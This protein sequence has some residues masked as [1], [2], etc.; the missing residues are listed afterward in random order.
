VLVA[1]GASMI[2]LGRRAR[3]ALLI[4]YACECASPSLPLLLILPSTADSHATG[5]CR[6]RHAN[7]VPPCRAASPL[8]RVLYRP[9]GAGAA[10]AANPPYSSPAGAAVAW[11]PGDMR[12]RGR[13]LCM[14][15]GHGFF[16]WP[17]R[18]SR[19]RC[20]HT[21]PSRSR[22]ASAAPVGLHGAAVSHADAE[23]AR[24][25]SQLQRPCSRTAA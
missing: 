1:C 10:S 16:A 14:P 13:G 12:D 18:A 15:P 21:P 19:K 3:V 17:R 5:R 23:G 9:M 22:V 2:A 6:F 24:A 8:M 4:R 25:A 7:G 11:A 20:G